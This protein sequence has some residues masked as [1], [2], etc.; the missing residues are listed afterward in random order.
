[1]KLIRNCSIEGKGKYILINRQKNNSIE[2][3]FPNTKEEFFVIKLKDKYAQA[4]LNAY[5][6]AVQDDPDGD[7][8]YA[9]QILELANRSGRDNQWC[10]KPT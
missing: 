5:V 10:K 7:Q 3:G 2:Y 6:M 1:M 8:E 9:K 4:A